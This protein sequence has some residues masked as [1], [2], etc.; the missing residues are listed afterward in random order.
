MLLPLLPPNPCTSPT[1]LL[2]PLRLLCLS[3]QV[4]QL[5][6]QEALSIQFCRHVPSSRSSAGRATTAERCSSDGGSRE[7]SIADGGGQALVVNNIDLSVQ[8]KEVR[9]FFSQ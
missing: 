2:R 3:V 6:P 7:G 5:N 8:Y 9:A 1:T 4:P